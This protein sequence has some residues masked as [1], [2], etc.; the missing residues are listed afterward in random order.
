MS[1]G[2]H[3]VLDTNIL[4]SAFWSADG[5]PS[6]IIRLIPD[7]IVVPYYCVEILREYRTVLMRPA[8]RFPPAKIDELMRLYVKYGQF[9]SPTPSNVSLPDESDRVFYDT[10]QIS[11]AILITGNMKHFPKEPFVMAPSDFYRYILGGGV[12]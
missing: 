10:A 12:K 2:I 3:A 8:F 9:V 6:K 7:G 1:Q 11:N 5:I 4:V